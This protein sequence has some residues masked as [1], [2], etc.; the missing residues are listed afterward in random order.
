MFLSEEQDPMLGPAFALVTLVFSLL[1]G[2]MGGGGLRQG[3][4]LWALRRVV[5]P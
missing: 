5:G 1:L 2:G 3:L 4:S